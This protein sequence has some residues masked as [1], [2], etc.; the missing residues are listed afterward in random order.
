ME[1][2]L[3]G[4]FISFTIYSILG[5]VEEEEKPIERQRGI[6]KRYFSFNEVED[7]IIRNNG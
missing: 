7:M 3:K 5:A 4:K 6:L 1:D 2:P